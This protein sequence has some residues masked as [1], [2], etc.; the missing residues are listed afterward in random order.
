MASTKRFY[1]S[2]KTVIPNRYVS[3]HDSVGVTFKD[4]KVSSIHRWYPYIEGFSGSF[5]REALKELKPKNGPVLDPFGGCGTTSLEC[6]LNGIGSYSLDVNPFMVFVSTV[7][8]TLKLNLSLLLRE[9]DS[10]IALIQSGQN[11]IK[12]GK[13]ISPLFAEM[14][15]FSPKIFYKIASLKSFI[16][17]V[18]DY[19][20]RNLF[21]LALSSILVRVSNLKRAPDLKFRDEPLLN[22]NVEEL[23]LEKIEQ[24]YHDLKEIQRKPKGQTHVISNSAKNITALKKSFNGRFSCII[25]S[26]PYLNG[27]NYCRNTKLEMWILDYIRTDKDLKSFRHASISAS[28]NTTYLTRIEPP[29]NA[30]VKELVEEIKKNAYDNRI[31]VMVNNYFADM[32]SALFEMYRLLA[33]KGPVAIVIGDSIFGGIHIP[34][35]ILLR[36]IA[37]EIGFHCFDFRIV[38]ERKSRSGYRL[39]ETIIYLRK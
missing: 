28:I 35:D 17:N 4:N 11:G 21:L 25:T 6:C 37:E 14:N 23:F 24:F 5:V 31:P 18:S 20:I 22:E 32:K 12:P 39:R 2:A 1:R 30:H 27:T 8:T 33:K 13:I 16:N 34:T 38:R 36:E 9:R 10:I 26:P 19:K 7:K 29:V 15:Y 3:K